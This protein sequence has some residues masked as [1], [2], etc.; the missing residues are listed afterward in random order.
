MYCGRDRRGMIRRCYRPPGD[1]AMGVP[2]VSPTDEES[3]E[4]QP[5]MPH[6][7]EPDALDFLAGGGDELS[8]YALELLCEDEEF[9]LYRGRTSTLAKP[10]EAAGTPRGLRRVEACDPRRSVR[11]EE[12]SHRRVAMT[13]G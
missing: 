9:I 13:K 10:P 1:G 8:D 3:S 4:R 5:R 2:A 6:A 7:P 11:A 12:G